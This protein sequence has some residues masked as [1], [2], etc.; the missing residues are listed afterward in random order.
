MLDAAGAPASNRLDEGASV[1]VTKLMTDGRWRCGGRWSSDHA[2]KL[3]SARQGG[4]RRTSVSCF[5]GT[6][7]ISGP[8]AQINRSE[9]SHKT[10]FHDGRARLASPFAKGGGDDAAGR[11]GGPR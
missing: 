5:G 4:S 9:P 7:R 10:V 3:A 8:S 1:V 11:A 2:M 6:K